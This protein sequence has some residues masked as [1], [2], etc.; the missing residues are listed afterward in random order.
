MCTQV[1][2]HTYISLLCQ[3]RRPRSSDIQLARNIPCI[4]ILV[5]T[6][7][8]QEKEPGLLEKQP[9]LRLEQEIYKMSM[10]HT[11]MPENK[12]GA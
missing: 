9:V 5:Y 1:S 11:V 7:I 2:L 8:L 10:D 12:A 4:Q 3:L 6:I